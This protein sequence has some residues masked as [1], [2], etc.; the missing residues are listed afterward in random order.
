[1][2]DE[3]VEQDIAARRRELA[4]AYPALWARTLEDWLRPDGGDRAWLIYAANYLFRTGGVRWAVDPI[5]LS[6]RLPEAPEPGSVEPLAELDFV[7]LTHLHGDHVDDGLWAALSGAPIVWVAPEFTLERLRAAVGDKA[8]C[9]QPT[10]LVPIEIAGI[11]ITPFESLHWE[12]LPSGELNHVPS[13]SYL[14]ET[15][16]QRL[17]LPGDTRTY[18]RERWPSFGPVDVV[19]AHVWGG[20]QTALEA[21]PRLLEAFCDF[22]LALEPARIVLAHLYELSR[23]ADSMWV[24]RH[25]RQCLDYWRQHSPDTDAAAPEWFTAI[26]L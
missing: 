26:D 16:R 19:F 13:F 11:R 1:M 7:L 3:R 2:K 17:L 14:V 20:R 8:T 12:W 22:T 15:P 6:H 10:P 23:A 9:I 24:D 18:E 21:S 5:R 25:A 4:E